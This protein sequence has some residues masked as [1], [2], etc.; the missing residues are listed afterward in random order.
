MGALMQTCASYQ[1]LQIIQFAD[2]HRNVNCISHS[3]W[4][5]KNNEYNKIVND[6]NKNQLYQTA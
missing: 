5:I 2:L 1:P 6:K 3:N 4:T